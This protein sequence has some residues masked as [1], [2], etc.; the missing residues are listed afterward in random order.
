MSGMLLTNARQATHT[1]GYSRVLHKN[2][3]RYHIEKPRR[4]HDKKPPQWAVL[5]AGGIIPASA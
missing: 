1:H 5:A 3:H 2:I 4:L